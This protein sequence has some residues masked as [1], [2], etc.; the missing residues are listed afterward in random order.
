META[1]KNLYALLGINPD[2]SKSAIK[3]A[4]RTLARKYHPDM[5]KGNKDS[6]KKFKE[7]KLA[8]EY[9]KQADTSCKQASNQTNKTKE[10]SLKEEFAKFVN[11]VFTTKEVVPKNGTDIE[12]ELTISI[13]EAQIG[14]TRRVNILRSQVCPHCYGKKFINTTKCPKCGG[15]GAISTHKTIPVQIP[16]GTLQGKILIIKNEGN[17][18]EN[19]GK[20]GDL[21]LKINIE[22]D[23]LFRFNGLNVLS[24]IPLSPT[25][26]ALGT[27]LQIKTIDGLISMKIPPETSSGQKF[28]LHSQGIFDKDTNKK[29]DHIVT[30]FIK[31]PKNLSSQ[32]KEL[33]NKLAKLR[34]FNPRE[35]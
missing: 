15:T 18:G 30:V 5:N 23:E 2:A 1:V 33:Y 32:E 29:G 13:Y 20:N 34:K 3:A 25:E 6:E 31:M 8:Y 21:K 24:D 17:L 12:I 7:I 9:K 27:T 16:A 4:F 22:K 35:V 26:A 28:R 11:E 19:G 10:T 14:T